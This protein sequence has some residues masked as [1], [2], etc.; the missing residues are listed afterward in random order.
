MLVVLALTD[1]IP[2]ELGNLT[3]LQRIYLFSNQLTGYQ[4]GAISTSQT[5]LNDIRLHNNGTAETPFPVADIN[6][7]CED[8][9]ASVVAANRTGE[10]NLSGTNMTQPTGDGLAAAQTLVDTHGWTVTLKDGALSPT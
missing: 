3:N 10:L 2:T 5:A 4:T 8:V 7:I 1:S 6:Q 9:L